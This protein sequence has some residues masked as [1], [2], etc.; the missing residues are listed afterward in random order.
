M[1]S[2]ISGASITAPAC[3]KGVAGTQEGSMNWISSAVF[4][5]AS[6]I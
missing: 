1:G 3:S 4:F 2:C 6:I 5:A